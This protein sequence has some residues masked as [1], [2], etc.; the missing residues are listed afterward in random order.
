MSDL[1]RQVDHIESEL[2]IHAHNVKSDG[3]LY[4]LE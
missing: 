1:Q 4:F 2:Q 3:K